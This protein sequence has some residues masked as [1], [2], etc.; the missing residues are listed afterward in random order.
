MFSKYDSVTVIIIIIITIKILD[1]VFLFQEIKV[2][3]PVI[4]CLIFFR[5]L[6]GLETEELECRHELTKELE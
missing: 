5:I 3:S 2:Q 4:N 1:K 6:G